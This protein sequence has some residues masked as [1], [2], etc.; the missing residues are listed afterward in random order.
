M[1]FDI[2]YQD[3]YGAL[4]RTFHREELAA[5]GQPEM[6]VGGKLLSETNCNSYS[7]IV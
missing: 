3:P 6:N 2:L 1:F 7:L 4:C 5:S